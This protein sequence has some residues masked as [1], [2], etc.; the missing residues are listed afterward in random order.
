[1]LRY[2]S[3]DLFDDVCASIKAATELS[4]GDKATL[5]RTARN[6]TSDYHAKIIEHA[7]SVA[8]DIPVDGFDSKPYLLG[9]TNGVV[10]L[11][12]KEFRKYRFDDYITLTT[13]RDYRLPD[14]LQPKDVERLRVMNELLEAIQDDS[15]RRKLLIQIMASGLDGIPY[16]YWWFFI[17]TGGNGKGLLNDF[18]MFILG[19]DLSYYPPPDVLKEV[20]NANTGCSPNIADLLHKRYIVFQEMGGKVDHVIMK[21]L[22]GGGGF[23]ARQ[24]YCGNIHFHLSA[25]FIGEM[26]DPPEFNAKLGDSEQRR[27]RFIGFDNNWTADKGKVGKINEKTGRPFKKANEYFVSQEFRKDMADVFLDIL[28]DCYKASFVSAGPETG[29]KFVVPDSVMEASEEFINDTNVFQICFKSLYEAIV[30]VPKDLD[31]NRVWLSNI[32]NAVQNCEVYRSGKHK[33]S[34]E[35]SRN[36]GKK[37][38]SRW[39]REFTTVFANSDQKEYILSHHFADGE[40]MDVVDEGMDLATAVAI[41]AVKLV[42]T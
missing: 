8:H 32:W 1:L 26:N 10:D 36:W 16:Q 22:T 31:E 17:G 12:T 2:V 40:G 24:P 5:L 41:G 19:T 42:E 14:Y 11:R 29:F 20:G 15:E 23:T 9:F 28:L 34:R 7:L 3:E 27:M 18:M 6:Q 13:G 39:I 25:T 37:K 30:P 21:K 33:Q 38:F 4:D 35:F